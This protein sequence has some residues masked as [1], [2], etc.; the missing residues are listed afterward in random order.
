MFQ[1]SPADVRAI[2]PVGPVSVD[3]AKSVQFDI[4]LRQP[5]PECDDSPTDEIVVCAQKTDQERYRLRRSDKD[6]RYE[7]EPR[8]A[9]F[10]ISESTKMSAE[11]EAA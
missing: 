9:E 4:L 6:G 8:K 11:V 5:E 3:P 10:S 1:S 2:D 7:K